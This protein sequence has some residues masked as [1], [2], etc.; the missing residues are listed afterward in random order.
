MGVLFNIVST[1][2]HPKVAAFRFTL[3]FR[4][5]F[6]FQHTATRRWLRLIWFAVVIFT[7]VST[8]SHPKV[9]ANEKKPVLLFSLVST[10]SHPKVAAP[11]N[12]GDMN[13]PKVSTHSHPKV[14]ASEI[15][16]RSPSDDRFQHTATRR[17]LLTG[18]EGE[19]VNV[20]VST[21]SHPKVAA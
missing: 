18:I 7:L 21:H 1:H 10:H 4:T 11:V 16:A 5:M 19:L 9:A 20:R 12:G 3:Y 15:N 17:W 6:L 8:H 2:S 13:K 14:A